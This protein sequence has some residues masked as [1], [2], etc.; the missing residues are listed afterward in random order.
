MDPHGNIQNNPRFRLERQRVEARMYNTLGLWGEISISIRCHPSV[1]ALGFVHIVMPA[2]WLCPP[3]CMLRYDYESK[4]NM[5]QLARF[6]RY[7]EEERIL[8][9]SPV[10]QT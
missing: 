8:E 4:Q 3:Q 5:A 9:V 2:P 6:Q 10:E 1:A 7:F